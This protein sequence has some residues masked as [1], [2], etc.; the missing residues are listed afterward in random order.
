MTFGYGQ[1][2]ISLVNKYVLSITLCPKV[3]FLQSSKIVHYIVHESES[4]SVK[5]EMMEL[6]LITEIITLSHKYN[7]LSAHVREKILSENEPLQA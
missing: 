6:L 4:N 3:E 1:P 5:D 2:Q 7:C